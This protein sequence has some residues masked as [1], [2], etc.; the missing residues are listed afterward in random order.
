MVLV[1]IAFA[2]AEVVQEIG[3]DWLSQDITAKLS[4]RAAQ[5]IGV[6]LL[7]ARLG[8]KA[9]EFCRPLAFQTAEKPKSSHIQKELLTTIKDVVLNKKVK[10]K[11]RV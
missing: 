9:M 6:G 3:M 2:G 11:E 4:A 1:N 7:T 8:I 10:E 5:G